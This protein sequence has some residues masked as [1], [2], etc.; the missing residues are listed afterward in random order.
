MHLPSAPLTMGLNVTQSQAAFSP[1]L[2][3][4]PRSK[5]IRGIGYLSKWKSEKIIK[6]VKSL[7]KNEFV[8]DFSTFF[9]TNHS[10]VCF[11][12]QSIVAHAGSNSAVR[13]VPGTALRRQ[14][15]Q[16]WSSN[17]NDCTKAY[18]TSGASSNGTAAPSRR[19]EWSPGGRATMCC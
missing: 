3:C 7:I 9:D 15:A 6:N 18:T 2:F 19:S 4:P 17:T 1:Q 16:I 11:G 13:S 10:S 8:K 5:L 12:Y 14:A